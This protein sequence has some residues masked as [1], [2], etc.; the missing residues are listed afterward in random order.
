[1]KKQTC[2]LLIPPY[3]ISYYQGDRPNKGFRPKKCRKWQTIYQDDLSKEDYEK[4]IEKVFSNM[5]G[6]LAP[7][8]PIYVFNAHKQFSAMYEM[9]T[10]RKYHISCVI[11]WAK[12]SFSISYGD[13]NQQTEFCLYG[14]KEDGGVHKWYGPNNET[15][16]WEI[17]RD[18]TKKYQ[19]LT[20]KPVEIPAR[21]I[22]N[23]SQRG[24]IVLELFG[25]SGSA[26][27]AAT[28]LAR[29][30]FCMEISE[31]FCDGIIRR[32]ISYIGQDK[33]P[34]DLVAKYCK[35]VQDA[36]K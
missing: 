24:N 21:A 10:K 31:A 36:N 3:G 6:Y 32:Y 26:L 29:R 30:C 13:Y 22:R 2:F 7:G 17:K 1:M 18:A 15:T 12:P 34:A 4:W 8:A 23:S 16:L 20:Q 14:W 11:T 33:A 25:G 5:D 19:H 27:I 9:L 35:E 28:S